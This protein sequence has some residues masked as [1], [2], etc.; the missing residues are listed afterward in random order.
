[1]QAVNSEHWGR[2]APNPVN[3]YWLKG[4]KSVLS[5]IVCKWDGLLNQEAVLEPDR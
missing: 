4:K 2:T 3:S 5:R 1:M